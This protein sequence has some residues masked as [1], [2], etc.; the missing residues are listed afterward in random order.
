[1]ANIKCYL[2]GVVFKRKLTNNGIA[3]AQAVIFIL[4]NKCFINFNIGLHRCI[5]LGV[6]NI[7]TLLVFNIFTTWSTITL[8]RRDRNI[9]TICAWSTN[10]VEFCLGERKL[11]WLKKLFG[12]VARNSIMHG[13]V[14]HRLTLIF[15][16]CHLTICRRLVCSFGVVGVGLYN[17]L[18]SGVFRF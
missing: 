18:V 8:S 5:L 4:F 7:F 2:L 1:M 15:G 13:K 16:A 10:F 17:L 6:K 3:F 12:L 11:R 14:I 9:Y